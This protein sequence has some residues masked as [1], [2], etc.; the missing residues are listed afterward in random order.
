MEDCWITRL[1]YYSLQHILILII[2]LNILKMKLKNLHLLIL[3]F[4]TS[5][6]LSAQGILIIEGGASNAGLLETT[7]NGDTTATGERVN[8]NRIYELKVNDFYIQH[9][10]VNVNNP[11]GTIT[12]RGQ[13]GGSKPVILKQPLNEVNIGTNEINS[14]LTFKNIQFHNQ[15]TDGV[16]PWVAFNINGDD[17][18]LIVEDCLIENCAGMIFNMNNVLEGAKVEIRNSYFRDFHDFGQW[19][20]GRIV[21]AKVPIDNF[22]FENNTVT[23]AGLTVLGQNCL[24]E[25]AV[26]NHNTFINN[27]KYPFLNQYWKEVYFT[28]NLFIN[29][30]MVGEDHE[31]VATGGQD[32]DALLHGIIGVDT[33]ENTIAIQSKFLNADSTLTDEVDDLSDII[34]YAADNVVVYTSTLDSYYNGDLSPDWD[35]APSSYLTWGGVTGPFKVANVPGIWKNSRTETLIN[36]YSN[37]KEENNSIYAISAADLGIGTDPLPQDA[38]DAFTQWNRNQ[39]GVPGVDAPTS[40][41]WL[42]YQFGDYDPTTV[43]GIETETAAAGSGGITK[44]SDVIEDFSYSLDLTSVSDG[45]RIGALHWDDETYDGVASIQAVKNAYNGIFDSTKELAD[46]ED[47]DLNNVPNPFNQSTIISF[48]LKENTEVSLAVFDISGR[49]V[50]TLINTSLNAGQHRVEFSSDAHASG[51]YFYRLTT[52]RYIANQKMV[53]VK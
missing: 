20:A 44:I 18:T 50:K 6:F 36:E 19:W 31:N 37:I 46:A 14:S 43:P 10:A 29:A 45:L 4:L 7:I 23:G 15:E 39:W 35:D 5:N 27:R 22:I 41:V 11:T 42:A 1:E 9:S 28:N 17:R 34:F 38:A 2:K 12:I 47:F 8:P 53:L 26:I 30:N 13:Q 51:T 52:D 48:N 32:P 25:Y 40:D 49:L 16:T 33:I 21:Q 3:L 24:F